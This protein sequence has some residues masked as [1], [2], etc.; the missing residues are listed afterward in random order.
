MIAGAG[1]G[2]LTAALAIAQRGLS[3]AVFDQAQ[4]L[5]EVGAGIQLSPNAY[6]AHPRARPPRRGR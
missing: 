1:I 2:G 4:R 5:E 3:V 6:G